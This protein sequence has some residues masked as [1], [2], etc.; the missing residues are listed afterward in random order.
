MQQRVL[1]ADYAD[2]SMPT[3]DLMLLRMRN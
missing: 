2:T 1:G 3:K